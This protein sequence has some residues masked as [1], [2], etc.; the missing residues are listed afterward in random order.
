MRKLVYYI[1]LYSQFFDCSNIVN[2]LVS[3]LHLVLHYIFFSIGHAYLTPKVHLN[4][5]N[6]QATH[7]YKDMRK[8]DLNYHNDAKR[9]S[10]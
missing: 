1:R 6:K 5:T 8:I 2:F 7:K 9:S 10:L 3:S 4:N